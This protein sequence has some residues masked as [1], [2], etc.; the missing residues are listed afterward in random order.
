MNNHRDKTLGWKDWISGTITGLLFIAEIILCILC[1]N[2]LGLLWLNLLGWI[3]IGIAFFVLGWLPR[4]AFTKY[5][6]APESESWLHTTTVVD[7]GIYAVVRHPIYLSWYFYFLGF[8]CISQHWLA[9][10]FALPAFILVYSD[11]LKEE[12]SN[13]QKFGDSYIAYMKRVPRLNILLGL[14]R[15]LRAK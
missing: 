4:V 11:T 15:I 1:F 12:K 13:I 14:T 2:S 9:V 8:I 3:L 7:R 10:A 6:Q 5:G